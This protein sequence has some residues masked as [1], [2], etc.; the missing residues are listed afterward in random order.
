MYFY[1]TDQFSPDFLTNNQAKYDTITNV[2]TMTNKLRMP[3]Q[4]PNSSSA[5]IAYS[6]ILM[7]I[8]VYNA[9]FK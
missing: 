2:I 1:A 7:K 6:P 4:L 5:M 3:I 9:Q 8:N